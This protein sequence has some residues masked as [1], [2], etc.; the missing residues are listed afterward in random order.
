MNRMIYYLLLNTEQAMYIGIEV[1]KLYI[2]I[3]NSKAMNSF[4]TTVKYSSY[5]HVSYQLHN[6]YVTRHEKNGLTSSV[7]RY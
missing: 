2:K 4:L 5:S 1:S 6:T 3:I 7:G